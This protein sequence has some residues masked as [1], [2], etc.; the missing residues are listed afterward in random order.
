MPKHCFMLPHHRIS[1]LPKIF[2]LGRQ[3]GHF[4][5]VL[6]L[7]PSH[8][9]NTISC[10]PHASLPNNHVGLLY[11]RKQVFTCMSYESGNMSK[12]T[13]ENLSSPI[14]HIISLFYIYIS[15]KDCSHFAII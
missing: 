10:L 3:P 4:D 2:D 13:Q 15:R 1:Q 8:L 6:F 11:F 12:D 7:V 14:L 9:Q 5:G